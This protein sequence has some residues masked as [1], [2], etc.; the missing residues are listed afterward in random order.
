MAEDPRAGLIRPN[1]DAAALG[2]PRWDGRARRV[3][4]WQA[5]LTDRAS[6]EGLWIHAETRAPAH[7]GAVAHGW[8]AHFPR[9]G[10]PVCERFGPVEAAPGPA[11]PQQPWFAAAGVLLAQDRSCGQAGAARWDLAWH[12]GSVPLRPVPDCAWERGLVPGGRVVAQ[13]AVHASGEVVVGGRRLRLH[14]AVGAVAHI[15]ARGW[16]RQWGWLHGDL[17]HGEVAE[18]LSVAPGGAGPASLPP[19]SLVQLRVGGRDWPRG[20][21]LAGARLRGRLGLPAWSVSGRVGDRRLRAWIHLPAS[22]C[23]TLSCGASD[24]SPVTR[25]HTAR[26]DADVVVERRAGGRWRSDHVW[27]LRGTAHAEVG[28]RP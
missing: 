3:E 25:T 14:D 28:R 20:P 7:G 2:R 26:A 24:G 15:H 6:G 18:I 11:G 13:P 9:R 1:D 12:D 4:A 16:P 17:G 21:L 8:F 5:T 23:V 19:G 10:A 27:Q 22:R